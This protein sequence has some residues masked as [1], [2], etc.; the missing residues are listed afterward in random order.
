M[1]VSEFKSKIVS[2]YTSCFV[3]L[4]VFKNKLNIQVNMQKG[5]EE[6]RGEI[7]LLSRAL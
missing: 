1:V 3:Y 5:K 6:Q 4:T 2:I 7:G